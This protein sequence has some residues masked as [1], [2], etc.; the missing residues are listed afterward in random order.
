MDDLNSEIGLVLG[1]RRP[2]ESK[3]V[4]GTFADFHNLILRGLT[5]TMLKSI[6][7]KLKLTDAELSDAAHVHVQTIQRKL[8]RGGRLTWTRSDSLFRVVRVF[9]L[10]NIVLGD[11]QAQKWMRTANPSLCGK[12]PLYSTETYPGAEKVC[13]LLEEMTTG[14]KKE[15]S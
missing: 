15:P 13:C 7:K 3:S 10:A 8:R 4:G 2:S 6:K 9:S 12:T 11:E 1:L 5:P 14:Q